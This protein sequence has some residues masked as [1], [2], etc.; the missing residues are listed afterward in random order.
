MHNAHYN[1]PALLDL[2]G[3]VGGRRILDAGCGA[4]SL[5]AALRARGA[6][7]TGVDASPRMLDLA[8]Q[9]LGTEAELYVADLAEP[10]PFADDE[11]DDVVASLVLHYLRDWGSVLSE[12][13][14]V[15]APGGRL[16]ISVEH[17][18]A[19]FFGQHLAGHDTTT[20]TP[21]TAS[22]NGPWAGRPPG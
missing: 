14:R 7:V 20:S 22:R 3:K 2:A 16:L 8:R 17:P 10:L 6:R 1:L 21:A 15:L 9:R 5:S 19:N 4:G 12:I 13:R 18:F 11:F